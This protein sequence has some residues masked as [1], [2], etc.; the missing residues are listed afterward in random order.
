MS[1]S[2]E[3]RVEFLCA[4]EGKNRKGVSSETQMLDAAQTSENSAGQMK[5]CSRRIL[6]RLAA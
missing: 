5:D 6:T 4:G 3:T 1:E 2:A